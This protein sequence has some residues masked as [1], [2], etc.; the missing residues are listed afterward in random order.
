MVTPCKLKKKKMKKDKNLKKIVVQ[1]LNAN[2]S[3][4]NEAT[5]LKKLR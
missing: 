5:I 1:P 3:V 4:L 2:L